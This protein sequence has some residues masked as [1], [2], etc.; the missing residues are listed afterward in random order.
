MCWMRLIGLKHV[1][2][3]WGS[4]LW[5]VNNKEYCG[6]ILYLKKDFR[7]SVRY[8]KLKHETF[9]L[10]SGKILLEIGGKERIMKSGHIQE[11]KRGI[12]HRFTG[13][14]DS[15]IIEFSTH[16]EDSDSYRII[17]GGK[18]GKNK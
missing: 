7:C 15:E 12:T 6:K 17:R 14:E 3:V 18:V 4:E 1:K 16:H 2:K 10:V 11:V 13:I 5:V 8:H 9:Y